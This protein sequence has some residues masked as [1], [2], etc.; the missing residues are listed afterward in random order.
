MQRATTPSAVTATDLARAM[1]RYNNAKAPTYTLAQ[2]TARV[3]APGWRTASSRAT[4]SWP[5]DHAV[6]S[7]P[8]EA[9][10]MLAFGGREH[11][12]AIA[13]D[14]QRPRRNGDVEGPDGRPRHGR[15][16]CHGQRDA[17]GQRQCNGAR[18]RG[19]PDG[20][21]GWQSHCRRGGRVAH[22]QHHGR[23]HGGIPRGRR[24]ALVP[25]FTW[26]AA[27]SPRAPR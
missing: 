26:L 22:Q 14:S 1:M 7:D 21:G 15:H 24:H 2:H 25:T 6:I 12:S 18:Q 3:T 16:C 4:P 13:S 9:A 11:D 5:M 8:D 19:G 20:S 10:M 23:G 27:S 17:Q